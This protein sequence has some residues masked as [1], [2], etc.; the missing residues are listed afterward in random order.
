MLRKKT[1]PE[2]GESLCSSRV[3]ARQWV[4]GLSGEA[5]SGQSA[6]YGTHNGRLPMEEVVTGR[7]GRARRRRVAAEVD[8]FL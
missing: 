7:A 5:G 6:T 8:E 4:R 1:P 2:Y 3:Q